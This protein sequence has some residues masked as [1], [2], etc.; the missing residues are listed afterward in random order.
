MLPPEQGVDRVEVAERARV[1]A[2]ELSWSLRAVHRAAS[3]V[4][5]ALA[6]RVGLRPLDYTALSHVMD[7]QGSSVGPAELGQRLGI[8]TGSA[9]E[10]VDR[11]ER[12]G[13]V[14]RAREG[15]DRRRVSVVPQ[16]AA[17]E[18]VLNHLAPAFAALDDL[19]RDFSIEEQ[20]AMNRYLRLAA[21]LLSRHAET[22]SDPPPDGARP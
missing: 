7:A 9:S 16:R 14:T 20:A 5:Q 10:L 19:A 11:L 2:H 17:V 13:H 4:D 8:S 12:A 22:L 18:R 6:Q 1:A 3:Q 21:E 15:A